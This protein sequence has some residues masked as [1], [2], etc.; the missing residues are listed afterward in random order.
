M[1]EKYAALYDFAEIYPISALTGEGCPEMVEGWLARL[2]EALRIFPLTS[3]PT[4]RSDSSPPKWSV[5]SDTR[6]ARR[7]TAR[8]RRAD[9]QF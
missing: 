6:H 3:S 5:K 7:S 1:I 4:S 2:P 9:R 8:H